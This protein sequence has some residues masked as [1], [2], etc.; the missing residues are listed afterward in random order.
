[1]ALRIPGGCRHGLMGSSTGSIPRETERVL[2]YIA[3][4]EL[5][6][7][8]TSLTSPQEDARGVKKWRTGNT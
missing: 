3:V 6:P 8:P 1:M 2:C 4:R 5:S 7:L